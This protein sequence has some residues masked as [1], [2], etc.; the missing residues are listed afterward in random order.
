MDECEF[1]ASNLTLKFREVIPSRLEMLD[2]VIERIMEAIGSMPCAQENL[3]EVRVALTEALSNAVIHGNQ[4]DP[5]K[6]VEICGACENHEK[7]LL[8]ITDQGKGFDPAAIP[9]P[10]VAE[11]IFSRRGR[12]IFLIHHLMDQTEFHKGGRQIV[13]RK[14][15]VRDN[16]Q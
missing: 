14:R 5:E 3:P 6:K 15:V 2:A 12:G 10:T 16:E 7:L 8:V 11:N 9:D 13:L 4:G 1:E